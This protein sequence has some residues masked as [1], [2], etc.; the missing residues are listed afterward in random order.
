M[1]RFM[2]GLLASERCVE[3]VVAIALCVNTDLLL[4]ADFL[5]ACGEAFTAVNFF[6]AAMLES[7]FATGAVADF[8][9]PCKPT[10]DSVLPGVVRSAAVAAG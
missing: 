7:V 6:G 8:G 10:S 3:R 1:T 2:T 9:L 5:A 4:D